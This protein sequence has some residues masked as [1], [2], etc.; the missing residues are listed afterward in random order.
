MAAVAVDP[1]ES[2]SSQSGLAIPGVTVGSVLDGKYRVDK[3]LGAGGMGVVLA[4]H[5]VH[6]NE[7][8]AIKIMLPQHAVNRDSIGRFIREAR[9]AIKIKSEHVA[10]VTDVGTLT[11]GIPYMVME[12]LDGTDLSRWLE[13]RG[14]LLLSDAVE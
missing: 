2:A 12:F 1:G 14:R 9:A 13:Q 7:R 11:D 3:I 4:A 8:V 10:R 5:H 6:L